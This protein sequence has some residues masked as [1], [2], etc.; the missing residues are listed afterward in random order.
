MRGECRGHRCR[1]EGWRQDPAEEDQEAWR[2]GRER[3]MRSQQSAE[4]PRCVTNGGEILQA[5][6]GYRTEGEVGRPSPSFVFS[7]C[8]NGP[9]REAPAE[10]RHPSVMDS[11][12]LKPRE[13]NSSGA[14]TANGRFSLAT[15]F[16][17]NLPSQISQQVYY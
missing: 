15:N 14:E 16:M 3:K 2:V 9:G 6:N 5:F 17:V 10:K 11:V 1:N 12:E 4:P 7:N 8:R 13:K